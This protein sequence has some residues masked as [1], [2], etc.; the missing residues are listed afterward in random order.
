MTDYQIDEE[1]SLELALSENGVKA[2]AKSRFLAAIDRL[3]CNIV[4]SLNVLIEPN[5]SRRQATIKGEAKIIS[6]LAERAVQF[7]DSDDAFARRA[8]ATHF[9]ET[10]RK[11]IN[12]DGVVTAA[13]EDLAR[14]PPSLDQS[15]F[16]P[17]ELSEEFVAKFE[18][19]AGTAQTAELRERWGRVLAGE[20]RRPGT[21]SRAVL[22][23]IDEIDPITAR[24]FEEVCVNLVEGML[25]IPLTGELH[26]EVQTRLV[27][28]G[29]L[30][31]PGLGHA[32]FFIDSDLP[33]GIKTWSMIL[34]DYVIAFDRSKTGSNKTTGIYTT[35]GALA[36]PVYL[37]TNVG[38]AVS[39]ILDLNPNQV[40]AKLVETLAKNH[41]DL[42]VFFRSS[43]SS[44][45]K[46]ISGKF[47][48]EAS[49]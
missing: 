10:A 47:Q 42:V 37:L 15:A 49:L 48:A 33:S 24:I 40:V 22:R 23:V 31:N 32:G 14:R 35:Q 26:F 17:E 13:L 25:P 21:F 6:A 38:I 18:Q 39:S 1:I 19:Y 46:R 7:I 9:G 30:I 44:D 34:E 3:G 5:V 16:G 12:K 45:Y 8:I 27:E 11:Q 36:M 41:P 2:K 4:E 43:K 20:V 29:L 28:A